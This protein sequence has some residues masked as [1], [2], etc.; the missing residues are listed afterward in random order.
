MTMV[1]SD[2]DR[3][4]FLAAFLW[5]FSCFLLLAFTLTLLW[6]VACHRCKRDT[7]AANARNC[8]DRYRFAVD[9]HLP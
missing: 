2:E 9:S 6:I 5:A 8:M 7:R 4:D 3:A 1:W